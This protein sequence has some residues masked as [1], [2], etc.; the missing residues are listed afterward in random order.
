MIGP[1]YTASEL[2][3]RVGARVIGDGAVPITGLASIDR[4][5]PGDLAHLSSSAWRD[6]LTVCR[7]SAVI[8]AAA[9]ADR[10]PGT[11][12]VVDSPYLAYARLS[13]LF[14]RAPA[15]AEGVAHDASIHPLAELGA[16]VAVG[17]G[18]R[19]AAGARIG[20]GCS[21]GPN[22]VV[23]EGVLIGRDCRLHAGA[24][25]CHGVRMGRDCVVHPGAVIGSDG[26][27]FAEDED[28]ARTAIAQLGG[29]RLGDRVEVGAGT[30]ID[31]GALGDT[32]I[33][34]GVKIDNQ[35]QIGHNVRIG[36]DTVICGCTGIAGSSVIGANC[37]LAGGVGI[38][39]DGPVSIA[40]NCV[41][42]GM[43]HVSRSI[44]EAGVYSSGTL[45]QPTRSWKRN[46]IRLTSLDALVQRV[47]ELERAVAASL[48]NAVGDS[49]T[50]GAATESG[51]GGVE[52]LE[53]PEPS[54]TSI[55][56][57]KT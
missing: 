24:V 37:V 45:H 5:G 50:A 55:R 36:R 12:L 44:S 23:S 41:I 34:S 31:R 9:D 28:G 53:L 30:S 48:D 7:A 32:V 42:S 40:D 27:G 46:A 56:Q 35:V 8:V 21:L 20:A 6:L 4:A 13:H 22:V 26:F 17:S 11:A 15:L 2:A 25:I 29:V 43:T 54:R 39:G 38:G 10:V 18:V 19:I 49:R 16:D 1:E 3:Q 51:G 14:D 57:D 52:S 47:A 33:E